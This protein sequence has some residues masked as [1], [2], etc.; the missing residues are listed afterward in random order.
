MKYIFFSINVIILN[1]CFA[2]IDS[3]VIDSKSFSTTYTLKSA[4]YYNQGVDYFKKDKFKEAAVYYKLA[5]K[6]DSTVLD[7]YDNLGLTYRKLNKLDSALYYYQIS[8]NKSRMNY[9]SILNMAVVYSIYKEY[10]I[11]LKYFKEAINLEPENTEGYYGAC[12]TLMNAG[13]YQDALKYGLDAEKLYKKSNSALIGDCYYL[14]CI[15]Y[16]NISD[17]KNAKKYLILCKNLNFSVDSGLESE[18]NKKYNP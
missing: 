4:E 9:T 15:I 6:E 7:I 11:S 1:F 16:Y 17:Y 2:Q 13:K 8:Y 10:D 3:R 5:L 18:I 14:L 12:Q